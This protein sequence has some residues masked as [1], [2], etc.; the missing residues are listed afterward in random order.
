MERYQTV[1]GEN[2]ERKGEGVKNIFPFSDA[3]R[4]AGKTL[5]ANTRTSKT[6]QEDALGQGWTKAKKKKPGC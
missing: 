3:K 5:R 1:H 4:L 2:L 6:I